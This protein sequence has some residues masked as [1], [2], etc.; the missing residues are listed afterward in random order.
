M[1]IKQKSVVLIAYP[2]S[3]LASTKVR[4]ALIIS[5]NK[6]NETSLDCIAVPL[7]TLLIEDDYSIGITQEDMKTGT[8]IKP[9]RVRVDKVFAFDKSLIK[10][11][12]GYV[13]DDYFK[14]I[15]AIFS[16]LV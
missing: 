15:K 10:K 7:T 3:N 4:P 12:I 8:L 13:Q 14:K 9:S 5:S 6:L 2:L 1:E 11:Q 16:T